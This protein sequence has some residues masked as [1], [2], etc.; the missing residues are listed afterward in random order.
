M[1]VVSIRKTQGDDYESIRAAVFQSIADIGGIEDVIKPGFK[2][3]LKPN[4][5]AEPD[6]RCSGGITRWEVVQAVAELVKQAG[7]VP[8]VAESSAAGVDTEAVVKKCEYTK[9]REEG[10]EVIDL[11]KTPRCKIPVPDYKL[12]E[13]MSSWELVRDADAIISIPVL[14]NHDQTEVTLGMKNLKGLIDDAQ[15]KLFHS[16]GV[17][18]GVVDI[19]QTVK[20]VLCVIDG[21][22]GQQGLGP[23][24]GET[25]KMDLI[26]ASKDI[27]SADAVGSVVMG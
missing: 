13:E 1:S 22:Y 21:T 23:I 11:K 9:M 8:V 3:I 7:A 6:E 25:V 17:I 18:D 12:I 19:V 20:P 14:K 10:Y 4:F 16:I 2:V 27:V 5:C 15:K 26:V 24:F